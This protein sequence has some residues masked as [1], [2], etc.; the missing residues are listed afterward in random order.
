MVLESSNLIC[1]FKRLP[2]LFVE[3]KGAGIEVEKPVNMSASNN[4]GKE[5]TGRKM[6]NS[7]IQNFF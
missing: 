4:L 6:V 7:Q 2:Q 5:W 1:V 3:K